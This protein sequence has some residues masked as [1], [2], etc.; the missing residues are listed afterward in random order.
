MRKYPEFPVPTKQCVY[1]ILKKWRTAWPVRDD[2]HHRK[3]TVIT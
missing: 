3:G 2:K 1:K